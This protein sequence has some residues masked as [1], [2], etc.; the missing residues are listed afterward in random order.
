MSPAIDGLVM[1]WLNPRKLRRLDR[2]M[3]RLRERAW[4]RLRATRRRALAL[5]SPQGHP[6]ACRL[7]LPP[8]NGPWPGVLVVPGGLDGA[9]SVESPS[10][11]LPA[12][13]LARAGLV[14]AVF[15]PSGREGQGGP[16]DC[17]GPLHQAECA[18]ALAALLACPEVADRP[19]G[20][21]SLSFGLVMA[22]GALRDRPELSRRVGL[23]VDWE[24]PGSRRWFAATPIGSPADDD[25]F[26]EPREGVR[27]VHGLRVPYRR[28]QSAWDHVHGPDTGIGWEMAEAAVAGGCPSVHLNEHGLPL[29]DPA[30]VRWGPA[31][32]SQQGAVLLQWLIDG[33]VEVT[34][35]PSG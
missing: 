13:R 26:W 11:V 22:L 9:A 21:L 20:V 1:S 34:R 25:A 5:E 24:G 29:P 19:V 32:R 3:M 33:L 18:Q 27:L 15:S 6:L 28:F 35:S 17:N 31:L 7:H 10:C 12:Q 23:L 14:A 2:G 16:A 4:G 30:A 8:G